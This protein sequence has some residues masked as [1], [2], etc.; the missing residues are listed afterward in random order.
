M[1]LESI[2]EA[3]GAEADA[4]AAEIRSAAASRVEQILKD[5]EERADAERRRW[6]E[7]RDEEAAQASEAIVNRARLEA[8]RRLAAAREDLFQAALVR[9]RT[10]I[11][12]LVG[13]PGYRPILRA[14]WEEAVA[15]VPDHDAVVMVRPQDESLIREIA[16][17]DGVAPPLDPT[18]DCAGGL[19][20][21]AG[22]GRAVRN[23]IDARLSRSE[24]H[25]RK[26][27]IGV[28]PEFASMRDE[29]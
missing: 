16:G 29:P 20:I 13:G 28:I 24:R 27:A 15:V 11:G 5:A 8:D 4:E 9:L 21:V 3:I 6:E 7:S 10:R 26:L 14:L 12:P 18:L 1:P 23:T 17:L 22:D 19:D 2:I 25:L